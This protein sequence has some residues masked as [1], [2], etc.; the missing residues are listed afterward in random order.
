M[1]CYSKEW[2][3]L[4]LAKDF[5]SVGRIYLSSIT[6]GYTPE[7]ISCGW[8]IH[9]LE[10]CGLSREHIHWCTFYF[11]LVLSVKSFLGKDIVHCFYLLEKTYQSHNH[12][13]QESSLPRKILECI[14]GIYAKKI[15]FLKV[16]VSLFFERRAT[17][18]EPANEWIWIRKKK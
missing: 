9:F 17:H 5:R 7:D 16:L 8:C 13:F 4:L 12:F 2:G 14:F 6:K 3:N 15:P 18:T 11:F 1:I 10:L